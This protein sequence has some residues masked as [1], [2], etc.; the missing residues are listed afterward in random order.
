MLN[1][2]RVAWSHDL[3][4]AKPKYFLQCVPFLEISAATT[5]HTPNDGTQ[6]CVNIHMGTRLP[7]ES[8]F[9]FFP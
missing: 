9:R 4:D 1:G 7:R 2:A 3:T 6:L 5:P 8:I